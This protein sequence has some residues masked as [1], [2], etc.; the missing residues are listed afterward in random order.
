M[1][2][3][4]WKKCRIFVFWLQ[5]Y[6]SRTT[7]T[8]LSHFYLHIQVLGTQSPPHCALT[9][10]IYF[11]LLVVF[12]F[13]CNFLFIEAFAC[14]E[15]DFIFVPG[16]VACKKEKISAWNDEFLIS[17]FKNQQVLKPF[18]PALQPHA[19]FYEWQHK[20]CHLIH[21]WVY[22]ATKILWK[23]QFMS[24]FSTTL[25]NKEV[26]AAHPFP[27]NQNLAFP[28][29]IL[30]QQP[31]LDTRIDV[32]SHFWMEKNVDF[33][34]P[35]RVHSS[36][37]HFVLLHGFLEVLICF[38]HDPTLHFLGTDFFIIIYIHPRQEKQT[39]FKFGA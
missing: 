31:V 25:W 14:Q 28:T 17:G 18:S 15:F 37:M 24:F 34:I 11:Q 9:F 2:D 16:H 10:F 22:L 30:S 5:S 32:K 36:E 38:F 27:R 21:C 20:S 39:G 26:P 3:F 6:S 13:L 7:K 4:R 35:I 1:A 23:N 8:F 12:D 29:Q 33:T 19:E